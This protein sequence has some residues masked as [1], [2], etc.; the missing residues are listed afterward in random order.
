M[1]EPNLA[2]FSVTYSIDELLRR[3]NFKIKSGDREIIMGSDLWGGRY[4]DLVRRYLKFQKLKEAGVTKVK[5]YYNS[6]Y[7]F[8]FRNNA[9]L[10][11]PF[12]MDGVLHYEAV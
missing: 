9:Q 12:H 1:I 7:F 4:P 11:D 10:L 6:N 2:D 3:G 8:A 5:V